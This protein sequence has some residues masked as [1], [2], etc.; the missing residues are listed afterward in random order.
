MMEEKIL[1]VVLMENKEEYVVIES[2]NCENQLN[3]SIKI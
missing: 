2:I 3:S 1:V